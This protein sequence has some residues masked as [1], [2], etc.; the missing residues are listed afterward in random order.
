MKLCINCTHH[1][2]DGNEPHLCKSP[3]LK[4]G[5]DLVTGADLY[6]DKSCA[7]Q[8]KQSITISS[9]PSF[10]PENDHYCTS[11]GRFWEEANR[12]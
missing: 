6:T 9:S 8:R 10:F 5:V 7:F 1:Y 12:E 2:T 11:E 4:F 3:Q